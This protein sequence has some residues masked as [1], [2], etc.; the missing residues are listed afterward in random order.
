M[1]KSNTLNSLTSIVAE[2]RGCTP[3]AEQGAALARAKEAEMWVGE[4]PAQDFVQGENGANLVEQ[5]GVVYKGVAYFTVNDHENGD[6]NLVAFDA[7]TMEVIRKFPIDMPYDS[8][9]MIAKKA[10][11]TELIICHEYQ[12]QNSVACDINTGAVVWRSPAEHAG[13]V[14]SGYSFLYKATAK[15]SA[16]SLLMKAASLLSQL[17][18]V[19]RFGRLRGMAGQHLPLIRRAVLFMCRLRARCLSLMRSRVRL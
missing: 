8:S 17:R 14:F 6:N 4:M 19:R 9:P 16:I 15:R 12:S 1:T 10:D 7:E 2:L 11:G 13:V 3:S 18:R 5:G